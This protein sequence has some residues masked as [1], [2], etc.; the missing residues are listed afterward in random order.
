MGNE[1]SNSFHDSN[2]CVLKSDVHNS[3]N[4]NNDLLVLESVVNDTSL[5]E[6]NEELPNPRER[7][8]S[9][10]SGRVIDRAIVY[11]YTDPPL[12]TTNVPPTG[13]QANVQSQQV[14]MN[15]AGPQSIQMSLL[16]PHGSSGSQQGLLST[17][18]A[19]TS[20]TSGASS[21]G[22]SQSI[23]STY[24]ASASATASCAGQASS[25]VT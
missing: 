17:G 4:Y 7:A 9:R 2:L 20:S 19:P 24:N 3:N 21:H 14:M 22:L 18:T 13:G 5:T 10:I 6:H 8:L 11:H 12:P 15:H 16:P 23:A 25:S 1:A